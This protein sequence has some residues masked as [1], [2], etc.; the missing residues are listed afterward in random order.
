MPF[1]KWYRYFIIVLIADELTEGPDDVYKEVDHSVLIHSKQSEDYE[2]D[3][4]KIAW[5]VHKTKLFQKRGFL[6]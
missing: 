6:K 2:Y 5:K 1:S 4:E 3:V